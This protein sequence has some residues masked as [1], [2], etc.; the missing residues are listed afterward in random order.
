MVT[1]MVV[2]LMVTPRDVDTRW[3]PLTVTL[4]VT[5]LMVTLLVVT[6]THQVMVT[7]QW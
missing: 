3:H 6:P 4:M 7:R 2:T 5:P 1:L